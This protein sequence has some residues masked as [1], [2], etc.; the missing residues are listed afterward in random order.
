MGEYIPPDRFHAADSIETAFRM[1]YMDG[2]IEVDEEWLMEKPMQKSGKEYDVRERLIAS[3]AYRLSDADLV[4]ALLGTGTAGKPVTKLAVEV[5]DVID[6]GRK[7]PDAE[8]LRKVGGMGDAKACAV[9]AALELGRRFYGIRNR[10][11]SSPGDIYP[12]VAHLA[13]R[14]QERFVC[15]SLNGAHEVIEIRVVSAGLVNRTIV[16]PREVFADP[17]TD[18]ACAVI[19]AHNHP[20]GQL[21][22]SKED[23]DITR[24]LR[25]ASEILGLPLLDHLVFSTEG[26][27]SFVEHGLMT[28]AEPG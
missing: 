7:E 21:E 15:V 17:I 28:P 18:R 10:R 19:V 2:G 5:L 26:Y 27:F 9:A 14:K 8:V 13:D 22:P 20:S 24:K 25:S 11:I 1:R 12:L 23:M 4:A 6:R 3:G 16:H